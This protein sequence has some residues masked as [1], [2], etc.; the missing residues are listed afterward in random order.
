MGAL[1][2]VSQESDMTAVQMRSLGKVSLGV[3][4]EFSIFLCSVHLLPELQREEGEEA[5]V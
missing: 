5:R 4:P 2:C 1:F 3:R